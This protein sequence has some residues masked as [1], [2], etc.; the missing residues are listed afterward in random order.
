MTLV[1]NSYLRGIITVQVLTTLFIYLLCESRPESF[2]DVAEDGLGLI[3]PLSK[4]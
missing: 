3:V 1:Q 2:R 4:R